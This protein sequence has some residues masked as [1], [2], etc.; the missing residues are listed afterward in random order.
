MK[1]KGIEITKTKSG[2]YMI[3]SPVNGTTR[4]FTSKEQ[5]K[6]YIDNADV[7]ESHARAMRD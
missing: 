6:N 1:Y 4:I 2:K 5:L 3:K 7:I